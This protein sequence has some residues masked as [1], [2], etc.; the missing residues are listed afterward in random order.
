[1]GGSSDN[2]RSV[3]KTRQAQNGS[4]SAE[5]LHSVKGQPGVLQVLGLRTAQPVFYSPCAKGAS[6][7]ARPVQTGGA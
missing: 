7:G 3:T 5:E 6:L 2:C 4:E 1:M